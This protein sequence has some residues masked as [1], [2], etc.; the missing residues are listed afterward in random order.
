MASYFVSPLHFIFYQIL[1]DVVQPY[2]SSSRILV[3]INQGDAAMKGHNWNHTNNRP[4]TILK[5]YLEDMANNLQE[6]I[7]HDIGIEIPKPEY[8]SAEYNYNLNKF[9]DIIINHIP[10]HI[11]ISKD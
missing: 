4:K 9:M 6:T 8:Y 10:N 7:K 2:I 1:E 5:Q 3:V 11:R